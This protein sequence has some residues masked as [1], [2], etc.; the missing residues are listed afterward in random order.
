MVTL[1]VYFN[2]FQ[3]GKPRQNQSKST[4]W[5]TIHLLIDKE[6]EILYIYVSMETVVICCSI[7][8]GVRN[9]CLHGNSCTCCSIDTDGCTGNLS[10]HGNCCHCCATDT[11]GCTYN[12]CIY[13]NCCHYG[14]IN[15]DGCT[16]NLCLHGN[17]VDATNGY[18]CMFRWVS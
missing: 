10:I 12:L 3:V 8:I 5:V 7:D 16:D 2:C 9:L 14:S 11:D 13:G 17:C 4:P 1:R 15:T 18:D 6:G